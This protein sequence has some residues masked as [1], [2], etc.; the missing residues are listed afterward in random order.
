L[1][2]Y[3]ST[4]EG[5]GL[6]VLEAMACGIPVV[7]S[8]RA[9]IPEVAGCSALLVDPEDAGA[10]AAALRRVLTDADL[11]TSLIS[12]G[13]VR[14]R[15]FNWRKTAVQTLAVYTETLK[16]EQRVAHKERCLSAA[17]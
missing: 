10:V 8:D 2:A 1:V 12:S 7:A 9:S 17:E 16:K 5:F 4:Y 15:R 11:R 6:P 14:V 13:L 3:L